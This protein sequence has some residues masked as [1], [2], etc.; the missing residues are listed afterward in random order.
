M[1]NEQIMAMSLDDFR[2]YFWSL[3][4]LTYGDKYDG[5]YVVRGKLYKTEKD[6]EIFQI[7]RNPLSGKLCRRRKVNPP[8]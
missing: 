5:A 6:M 3:P 2:N 8:G 4:R 1:T 7:Y